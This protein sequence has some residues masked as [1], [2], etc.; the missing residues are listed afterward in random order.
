MEELCYRSGSHYVYTVS[1]TFWFFLLIHNCA[2]F[3]LKQWVRVFQAK[4]PHIQKTFIFS[5]AHRAYQIRLLWR[6]ADPIQFNSNLALVSFELSETLLRNNCQNT[7]TTGEFSCLEGFFVLD[8][9]IGYYMIH[10]FMPS[11]MCVIGSWV[12]FWI[13]VD[14]APARVTM[15][16]ATFFTI[17]QQIQTFNRGLPKVSYIK[18]I[19]IWMVG[20]SIFVFVSILEYGIAQVFP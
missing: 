5:L 12:S 14:Q 7:Y 3:H 15:G 4:N 9:D 1:W 10:C 2:K 6:T 16:I 19:D 8:R 20:C 11:L 13:P 18:S 17:T